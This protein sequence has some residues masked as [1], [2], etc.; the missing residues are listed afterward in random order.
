MRHRNYKPWVCDECKAG[1]PEQCLRPEHCDV[2]RERRAMA[3]E[4]LRDAIREGA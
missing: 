2:T 4:A 3:A 1:F